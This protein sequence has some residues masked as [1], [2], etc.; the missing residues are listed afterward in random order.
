MSKERV[1]ENRPVELTPEEVRLTRYTGINICPTV[2]HEDGG[3]AD[4]TDEALVLMAA[5][6]SL[7]PGIS[8]SLAQL[9]AY[10]A[11]ANETILLL[12][13]VNGKRICR[14]DLVP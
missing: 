14:I 6:K 9:C 11:K 12:I 13:E 4:A 1:I 7:P 5:F 8:F 2:V 3:P 10:Q